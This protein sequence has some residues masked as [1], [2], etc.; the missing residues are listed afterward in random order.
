[1]IKYI[2][3]PSKSKWRLVSFKVTL[4]NDRVLCPYAPSEQNTREQLAR[5]GHFFEGLRNYMENKSEGMKTK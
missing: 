3:K 4:F 1:M 5:R 2:S